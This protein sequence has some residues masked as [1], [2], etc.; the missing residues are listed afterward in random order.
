[1]NY[2]ETSDKKIGEGIISG[3]K[4]LRVVTFFS[5]MIAQGFQ[6]LTKKF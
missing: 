1:M 2:C 6:N 3:N 4:Y 5:T